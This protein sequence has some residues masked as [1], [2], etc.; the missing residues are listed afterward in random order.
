MGDELSGKATHAI[1][2]LYG[3]SATDA[4]DDFEAFA[5]FGQVFS[6]TFGVAVMVAEHGKQNFSV[7][8]NLG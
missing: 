1:R 6:V 2:D 5:E 8:I 7:F 3:V 4:I